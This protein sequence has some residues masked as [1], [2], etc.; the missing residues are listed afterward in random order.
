MNSLPEFAPP[1]PAP[2]LTDVALTDSAGWRVVLTLAIVLVL[3]ATTG[4]TALHNRHSEPG[5]RAVALQE[6][7]DDTVGGRSLPPADADPTQIA[8]F[9]GSLGRATQRRLARR[10]PLMVGNLDGVP[11]P[12][13]YRANRLALTAA[14]E[15]ERRR[16]TDDRLTEAGQHTAGRRMNRFASLLKAGRQ[17]LA[18]DPSGRGRAAEVFGDLSTARRI[19]V[20]VPGVDT[21]LLTFERTRLKY[22]A[23]VGMAQALHAGQSR[24][25]GDEGTATI[26][27]A[28][29]GAPRGV[30]TD[31]ATGESA[32]KGSERLNRMVGALPG[33][34]T[35]ALMCHS[36]GSVVCGLAAH[37][38]PERVTDI[39]VAG[40]PGVRADRAA[41]LEGGNIRL[42][43]AQATDDW[44]AEI[45]HLEL[46]GLGH[47]PD[48]AARRFGARLLSTEGV[49]GHTGYFVPGS[50]TLRSLA[51]LGTGDYGSVARK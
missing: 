1:L 21:D 48:P 34:A 29:Y 47:G 42:W 49:T 41:D 22:T 19:S 28:D 12:L 3:L 11:V 9:F 17:L 7:R 6:W 4:W 30:G 26:A 33:A 5:P 27:W 24:P 36:Y 23:P 43:A 39:A 50:T 14:V 25:G 38:A 31:A 18:F 44:I 13:R 35:V 10:H 40:S 37:E 8:V 15:Q 2:G 20:V 46:G 32:R 51:A 16:T 45:P